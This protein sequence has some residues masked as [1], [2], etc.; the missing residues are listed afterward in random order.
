M[1]TKFIRKYGLTVLFAAVLYV[2]F[3]VGYGVGK[4]QCKEIPVFVETTVYVE[5]VVESVETVTAEPT[6]T[7]IELTATAYCPCEKCCGVWAT[8]RPLDDNRGEARK[9]ERFFRSEWGQAL[10]RDNGEAIITRVREETERNGTNDQRLARKNR[11][12]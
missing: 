4:A 6:Y 2:A 11:E 12:P 1:L 8:N 9:L 7:E 10:S 3:L 5:N